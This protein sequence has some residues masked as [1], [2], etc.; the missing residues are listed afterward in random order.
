MIVLGCATHAPGPHR[1]LAGEWTGDFV[2][3]TG[4][5]LDAGGA[6]H[7]R[8]IVSLDQS[9][10]H[11]HGTLTGAGFRGSGKGSDTGGR[12]PASRPR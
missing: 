10:Q 7:G 8:M 4:G 12:P 6:S 3:V 11:I 2:P 9:G 5:L 1:D